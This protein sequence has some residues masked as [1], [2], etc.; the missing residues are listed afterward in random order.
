M[1]A[2]PSGMKSILQ[3]PPYQMRCFARIWQRNWPPSGTGQEAAIGK[4]LPI[5]PLWIES[6]TVTIDN[7]GVQRRQATLTITIPPGDESIMPT[8]IS[9]VLTPFRNYLQIWYY[10][11]PIG[12]PAPQVPSTNACFLLGLFTM[13]DVVIAASSSGDISITVD[14]MDWSQDI[15]RRVLTNQYVTPNGQNMVSAA[16]G[17]IDFA[18]P[19]VVPFFTA[20]STAALTSAADVGPDNLYAAGY[21][22]DPGQDPWEA[23]QQMAQASGMQLYF[24]PSGAL[25]MVNIPNPAGQQSCWTYAQGSK[26][27]HNN[28]TSITRTLSQSQVQNFVEM[29]IESASTNP[30]PDLLYTGTAFLA[31]IGDTDPTSPTYMYGPFGIAANVFYEEI[32]YQADVAAFAAKALLRSSL[33]AADMVTFTALPNPAHEAYDRITLYSTRIGLTQDY[34]IDTVELPLSPDKDM[35]ITARRVVNV[36]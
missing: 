27:L 4:Q 21:T 26:T 11:A 29:V 33:G 34:V 7:T 10:V 25:N 12:T 24:G 22:W 2:L 31:K 35:T 5:P 17:I 9:D 16:Q 1:Y 14:C 8:N 13:T 19:N 6:G 18:A 28:L 30:S 15:S 20:D 36:P 3:N 32:T 23:A